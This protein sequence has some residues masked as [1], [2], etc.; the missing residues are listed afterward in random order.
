MDM[1]RFQQLFLWIEIH[2]K[3]IWTGIAAIAILFMVAGGLNYAW[4]NHKNTAAQEL[5]TLLEK[6]AG[7]ERAEA[8]QAF[9]SKYRFTAAADLARWELAQHWTTAGKW[10]EAM[11]AYEELYKKAGNPL[12]RILAL[13]GIA[14]TDLEKG[15][16]P[17]A[18]ETFLRAA[19]EPK[20][21]SPE[22]S[23]LLAARAYIQGKDYA[24]AETLLDEIIQK[25]KAPAEVKAQAKAE[26]LWVL[27]QKE[28]PSS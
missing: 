1:E 17:K 24:K 6:P 19:M 23:R 4:D 3:K 8:L 18:A 14:K 21:R 7:E 20:N 22:V 12:L 26:K 5:S 2:Q 9:I 25:E 11:G 27:Y 10:E 13:H 28:L 15:D 16:I